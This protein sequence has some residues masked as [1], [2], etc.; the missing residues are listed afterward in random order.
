MASEN[1]APPTG[2]G[3]WP[4]PAPRKRT[5]NSAGNKDEVVENM[6]QPNVQRADAQIGNNG[7][8]TLQE[9]IRRAQANP[10]ILADRAITFIEGMD[11]LARA[12]EERLFLTN[13]QRQWLSN[14]R[15][16]LDAYSLWD[17]EED[18]AEERPLDELPAHGIV[19][20]N[21]AKPH[22]TG[23]QSK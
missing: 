18:T 22:Q 2:P 23:A 17:T 20:H 19:A 1:F 15:Q 7:L 5:G 16:D 10:E 3:R 9:T 12:Y 21:W 14:I 11:R 8:R 6:T 4:G 13:T